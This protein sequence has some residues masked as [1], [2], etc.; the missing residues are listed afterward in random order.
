M[1]INSNSKVVCAIWT[2]IGGSI[3]KEIQSART[4]SLSLTIFLL[5]TKE[6]ALYFW[7]INRSEYLFP[8]INMKITLSAICSC[9]C[10]SGE[11]QIYSASLVCHTSSASLLCC[12]ALRTHRFVLFVDHER[13]VKSVLFS[14]GCI[15]TVWPRAEADSRGS[16]CRATG[17]TLE[18]DFASTRPGGGKLWLVLPVCTCRSH[19]GSH[20][21]L[22]HQS[23]YF[24][25]HRHRKV[26]SGE[27][28][29][30][31]QQPPT[32]NCTKRNSHFL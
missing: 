19:N 16:W 12:L 3:H 25:C 4:L 17:G 21:L 32:V 9:Q 31:P 26:S 22:W 18:T 14:L 10:K 1:K 13:C 27:G 29:P 11:R 23:W 6:T 30:P 28:V 15:C 20:K 5:S 24:K 7:S 8:F 2:E